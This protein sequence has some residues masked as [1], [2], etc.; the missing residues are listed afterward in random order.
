MLVARSV[1]AAL[2]PGPA[3]PVVDTLVGGPF[4]AGLGMTGGIAAVL[5]M[6]CAMRR[7][8]TPEPT[9]DHQSASG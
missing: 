1:A 6:L 5:V 3:R 2:L 7:A 9:S 4:D 8:T